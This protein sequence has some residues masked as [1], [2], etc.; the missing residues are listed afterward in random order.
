MSECPD[1]GDQC[2]K[3]DG[4]YVHEWK[5]K[6]LEKELAEAKAE[7]ERLK[8]GAM[9]IGGP[10]PICPN[11]RQPIYYGQHRCNSSAVGL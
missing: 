7:I 9:G 4:Y 11:C 1:T 10:L 2:C 5:L 6:A 8:A 3:C